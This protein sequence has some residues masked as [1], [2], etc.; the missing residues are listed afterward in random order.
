MCGCPEELKGSDSFV[1]MALW[2]T[3][4]E[5]V[6]GLCFYRSTQT[7]FPKHTASPELVQLAGK[8]VIAC[9]RQ[10]PIDLQLCTLGSLL[11]VLELYVWS[12]LCFGHVED[13][14]NQ[15]AIHCIL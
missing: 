6:L 15:G 5:V 12:R 14:T 7:K 4:F 11:A 3:Q 10:S 8:E 1:I 13:Q 2:P 9:E